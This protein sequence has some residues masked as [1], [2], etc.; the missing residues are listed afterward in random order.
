MRVIPA[1]E[2]KA[3]CLAL[4][5]RVAEGHGSI[6]ISKHG[7]PVA[8]LVPM[9]APEKRVRKPLVGSVRLVDP[10]DD[11]FSTNVRWEASGGRR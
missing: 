3:R 11:L 4:L 8:R 1:T 9:D 10:D 6:V 7:R 2:F 5:D